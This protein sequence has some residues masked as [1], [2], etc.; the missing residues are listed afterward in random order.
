M[1]NEEEDQDKIE[2]INKEFKNITGI[3]DGID[4]IEYMNFVIGPNKV[5]TQTSITDINWITF[6]DKN[7]VITQI[8]LTDNELGNLRD[9]IDQLLF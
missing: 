2:R 9:A 1:D 7:D 3:T 5:L 6:V 8:E 4:D